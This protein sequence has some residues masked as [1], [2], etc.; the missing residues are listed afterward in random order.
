MHLQLNEEIKIDNYINQESHPT[1][2]RENGEIGS[3]DDEVN[4]AIMDSKHL[5]S[6]GYSPASIQSRTD[7]SG[8]DKFK[9][10]SEVAINF[11]KH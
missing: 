2:P 10:L 8:S 6:S 1:I 3:S 7:S 5:L 11:G 4:S 9:I